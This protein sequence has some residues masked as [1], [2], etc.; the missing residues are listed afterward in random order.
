[1]EGKSEGQWIWWKYTFTC[2]NGWMRP[3]ENILRRRKGDKGG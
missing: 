3:V 2:E 1:M